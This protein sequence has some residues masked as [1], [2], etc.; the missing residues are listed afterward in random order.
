[1]RFILFT[2][3][4]AA[5]AVVQVAGDGV[6]A[7][8]Q[9]VTPDAKPAP[10]SPAPGPYVAPSPVTP[11]VTP[12]VLPAVPAVPASPNTPSLPTSGSTNSTPSGP[13]SGGTVSSGETQAPY[14]PPAQ[15]QVAPAQSS[16]TQPVNNNNDTPPPNQVSPTSPAAANVPSTGSGSTGQGESYVPNQGGGGGA[17]SGQQGQ[18]QTPS[19]NVP[20]SGNGAAAVVTTTSC[21]LNNVP[22]VIPTTVVAP[23]AP[24]VPIVTGPSACSGG[25]SGGAGGSGGA[26]VTP[27]VAPAVN[28]P[29]STPAYKAP[30]AGTTP[31]ATPGSQ[32]YKAQAAQVGSNNVYAS[33][34]FANSIWASSSCTLILAIV[35]GYY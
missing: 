5:I 24:N 7:A 22:G 10:I 23:V 6:Y 30:M 35:I 21:T 20:G 11:P 4:L 32:P 26:C 33:H 28:V 9:P 3:L 12:P 19:N 2:A 13:S 27:Y 25:T 1:M 15:G 8:P 17:S 34:A 29:T 16:N 18:G 14:V 31:G